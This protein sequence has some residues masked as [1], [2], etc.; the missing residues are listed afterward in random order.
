MENKKH[1]P[2]CVDSLKDTIEYTCEMCGSEDAELLVDPFEEDMNGIIV[3]RWLCSS[4]YNSIA[5][6]I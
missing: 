1:V 5:G 6:D 3:M 4:C 2:G